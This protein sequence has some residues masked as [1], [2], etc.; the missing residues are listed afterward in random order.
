LKTKIK[1]LILCKTQQYD[2]AATPKEKSRHEAGFDGSN[3]PPL[4]KRQ[5]A[6]GRWRD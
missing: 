5:A 4:V 3:R 1:L 2:M 6:S